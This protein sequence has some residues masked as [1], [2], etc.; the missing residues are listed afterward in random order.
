MQIAGQY[1]QDDLTMYI[2]CG[3]HR[4]HFG[5]L[6]GKHFKRASS[7]ATE[8]HKQLDERM[9]KDTVDREINCG[10]S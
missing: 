5:V 8:T 1:L 10:F 2:V 9:H 6:K 7:R 3:M 4:I